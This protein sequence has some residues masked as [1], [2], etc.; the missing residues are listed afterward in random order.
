MYAPRLSPPDLDIKHFPG[1]G[2]GGVYFEASRGRKFIRL[3]PLYTPHP[4]KG[5]GC[6]YNLGHVKDCCKEGIVCSSMLYKWEVLNLQMVREHTAAK[7]PF[8]HD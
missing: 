8:A 7:V 5:S 1:E 6:V 3:P 4:Y 2:G